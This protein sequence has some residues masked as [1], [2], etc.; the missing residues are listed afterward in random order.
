MLKVVVLSLVKSSLV[1]LSLVVMPNAHM[2][3]EPP[4]RSEPSAATRVPP[5]IGPVLGTIIKSLGGAYRFKLSASSVYCCALGL[6]LRVC[7]PAP[8]AASAGEP[9][10]IWHSTIAGGGLR[11]S[12]ALIGPTLPPS[13]NTVWVPWSRCEPISRTRVP[14]CSGPELGLSA[15]SLGGE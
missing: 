14:P 8:S 7:A 12:V 9:S 5:K 10:G 11:A 6:S 13:T 2:Y 15:S 4:P 1:A 3:S